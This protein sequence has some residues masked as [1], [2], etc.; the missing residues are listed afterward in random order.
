MTECQLGLHQPA[1]TLSGRP[2]VA[3]V[4]CVKCGITIN[5]PTRKDNRHV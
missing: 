4:I 3:R 5:H 2:A 1:V